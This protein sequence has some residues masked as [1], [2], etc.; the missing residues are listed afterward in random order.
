L[1]NQPQT[2][3]KYESFS[4]AVIRLLKENGKELTDLRK[5]SLLSKPTVSRIRR[6]TNDKG[7]NY[8]PTQA[9]VMAVC[10]GLKL[11]RAQA[12]ELMFTA[13]PEMAL[14]GEILDRRLDIMDANEMLDDVGLPTLG[15]AK[16]E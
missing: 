9:V 2:E 5:L 14:W 15:N 8:Q 4:K 3:R 1:P 10:V 6:D 16:E 7:S 12:A 13:F 11:N